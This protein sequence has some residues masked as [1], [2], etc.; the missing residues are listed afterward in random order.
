MSTKIWSYMRGDHHSKSADCSMLTFAQRVWVCVS[1]CVYLASM[2]VSLPSTRSERENYCSPHFGVQ[3]KPLGFFQTNTSPR[4]ED[5]TVC[6]RNE[7]LRV[8]VCGY[9]YVWVCVCVCV[10]V[11]SSCVR[12]FRLAWTTD[13]WQLLLCYISLPFSALCSLLSFSIF[14]VNTAWSFHFSF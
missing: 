6:K 4:R 3:T 14:I 2:G 11:T 10:H 12:R 7:S 9:Q 5:Q 8:S 1:M 13:R